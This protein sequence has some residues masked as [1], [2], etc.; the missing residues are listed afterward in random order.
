[1]ERKELLFYIEKLVKIIRNPSRKLKLSL[2][3]LII[4]LFFINW[5][6]F[7][8]LGDRPRIF[9]FT[10]SI[11]VILASILYK[12]KGG[13]LAG[14]TVGIILL[15]FTSFFEWKENINLIDRFYS[16]G[17]ETGFYIFLGTLS[18][19]VFEVLYYQL[20][21]LEDV[22]LYDPNSNLPNSSYLIDYLNNLN[23]E[24]EGS[25]LYLVIIDLTNYQEIMN[26]IG[27][28]KWGKF[29]YEIANQ[30][31]ERL[32]LYCFDKE[33]ANFEKDFNIS[34]YNLYHDKIG[35]FLENINRNRFFKFL[36]RLKDN[37]DR[38]FYYNRIPLF[39]N[40][41]IGVAENNNE[42]TGSNMLQNASQALFSAIDNNREISFYTASLKQ[43]SRENWFLLGEIRSALEQNHFVLKYMPK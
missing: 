32:E 3:I 17:I 37:L 13:L 6:I 8:F 33:S 18:G 39:L 14:L 2:I 21:K 22:S 38:P 4:G 34:V 28:E 24:N 7:I 10:G 19:S 42:T 16:W 12:V 36:N 31:K 26:T 5:L 27:H 15:P 23:Q 29:I 25:D 43:K 30:L 11:P 40:S 1:M 20:N 41:H 9:V 35:F